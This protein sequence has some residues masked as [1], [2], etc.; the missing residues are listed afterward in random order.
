[1]QQENNIQTKT[2][3]YDKLSQD[4]QILNTLFKE[5]NYMVVEQGEYLDTIENNISTS[6]EEIKTAHTD[7]VAANQIVHTGTLSYLSN[8]KLSSIGAGIGAIT[9]LYN[10]YIA[11]GTIIMGGAIGWVLGDKIHTS[12]IEQNKIN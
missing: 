3:I 4:V 12:N 5:L 1:M 2:E 10:P 9:L 8:L 6:K 11:I 7:L